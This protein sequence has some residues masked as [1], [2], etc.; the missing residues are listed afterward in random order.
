MRTG[1]LLATLIAAFASPYAQ[2]AK[3]PEPADV[4]GFK[5]GTDYKLATHAQIVEYFKRLDAA[6]DRVVVEEIGKTAENRPLILA[7]ISSEANIKNRARYKEIA[8]QLAT[9]RGIDDVKARALAREGKAIVWIDGGLHATEVAHAQHTPELGWWVATSESDEAKRMRENAI[10]LLMPVMNPDGLEVVTNWYSRNL[11]TAFE[12]TSPPQLYHHYIGHDNNRDWYM[13]TQ[14]ET[15]AVGRILYREWFPQI[16][17]NHHQS[18]PFPGRIWGPPMENPVNPN[19]DPLIVSTINQIGEAMRKR[20]DEEE[21]PGYNSGIVFDMWWNGSMRGAPDFHNMAGFL[22]ETAGYRYA[23]PKCYSKEEIPDTFGERASNLDAKNPSTNYTNPWLGGCWPL[24]SA[25][26]YMLTASRAV[27]NFGATLKEDFLFNIWRMGT[28]QI[29]RGEKA[30]GGPYAYVIDL[31]AQHDPTATTEFLRTFS[32]GG[33]EIRQADTPFAAGGK[34]YPAGTYVIGPQ[35]FRPYVIDLMEPKTYPDRRQYPGGP[36]E[37]PYDMTGYELGLQMGVTADRVTAPF[38]LPARIVDTIPVAPPRSAAGGETVTLSRKANLSARDVNRFLKSGA[39]VTVAASGDFVVQPGG[40][41]GSVLRQPRIGLYRSHLA[42]M[43]EG[44]TRWVLEQ[45]E[46]PYRTLTDKDIRSGD[47]SGLD[48][49]LFADE[50]EDRIL[51]GHRA[52]TMPPE[53]VGGIGVEGAAALKRYVE[54]GG[55]VFAWDGAADFAISTFGLPLRNTV[56]NVRDTDFFIPGS[57]VRLDT[58][59][60]SPLAA[61]MPEQAIAFFVQSQAFSVIPAASEGKQRIERDIEVFASYAS[62]DFLASGWELGG[63]RY[64]AGRAAGVRVP[65]GKG[66]VVVLAFRPHFRG[67]PHN[68]FKLLF[69]PIFAAAT[70]ASHSSSQR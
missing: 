53:F 42:N 70:E 17:Y 43:D 64:A 52:G 61:G 2:T 26:D 27:L 14:N 54:N 60:S 46:F 16:V 34:Q 33:V 23:T 5:P 21:K 39:R 22:T 25:V 38:P 49:I 63:R 62:K 9:A 12:T 47:L 56:R 37:P 10:L 30:V 28:R 20:F 59:P 11:G 7:L 67:Q 40:G 57:L 19:L 4:F 15:Q 48:I 44:W 8:R 41:A 3:V 69:N 51:N 6:S 1:L 45:Y 65:V 29:A 13:F 36:P 35:A 18:S 66:Q 24:R 50:E 68:T 32:R 55:W 31:A 58:K